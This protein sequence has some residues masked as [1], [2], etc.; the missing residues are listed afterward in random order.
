MQI[1]MTRTQMAGAGMAGCY[2]YRVLVTR[3]SV[4]SCGSR[5]TILRDD[6]TGRHVEYVGYAEAT[7]SA[8]HWAMAP[9]WRRY[10]HWKAHEAEAE[11][12]AWQLVREHFPEVAHVEADPVL[13][14][15]DLQ[16]DLGH[17][18]IRIER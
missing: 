14:A 9:G 4:P 3:E 6:G 13:W 5:H 8:S 17:A 10:E 1:L 7:A 12:E 16:P 11:R 15:T 2:A 18:E